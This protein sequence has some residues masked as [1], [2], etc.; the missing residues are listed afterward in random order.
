[1]ITSFITNAQQ[2]SLEAEIKN[3][4][5]FEKKK[6]ASESFE[7]V[8]VFDVNNDEIPDLVSGSYW[9]EGPNYI[10]RHFIGDFKR[11]GEYYDDFSTLP[12]DV[13]GDGFTDYITGGWFDQRLVWRENP[14]NNDTWPEH[15]IG[16]AGNIEAIR[17]WD[18]DGD[19]TPEIVPNTPND[20]LAICR[21]KKHSTEKE[22]TFFDIFKIFGK[23]DHGLGFGDVN[24]DGK[25]DFILRNGWLEAPERPFEEEWVF[26]P[27]F[28]LGKASIPILVV[29]VNDDGLNDIISGQGHDYGLDWYGQ[30]SKNGEINWVKHQI[31]P[32]NSQFHTMEWADLDGDGKNGLVTGKRY[33]AHNGKDPGSN[34]PYGIYY[35]EFN[36]QEFVKQTI[37][38]GVFGKSKG[39]GIHFMIFDLN[40]SGLKDIVVAGKD[41]LYIYY[42]RNNN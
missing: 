30:E 5:N 21:L 6:I 18:I 39:T 15:L 13:N 26:H 27:V 31:D 35:Y 14:G 41:G 7:S 36:G 10:D 20:S 11:H 17:L 24:G 42:N 3:K 12:L 9:Y 1:M 34:D 22:T 40:Q 19:G 38:Y 25:G 2:L 32:N 8:G 4:L 28:D 37:D 16:K 33:R 23:H 29:D